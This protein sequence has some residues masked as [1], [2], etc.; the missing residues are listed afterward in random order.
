MTSTA[1]R[2]A[3]TAAVAFGYADDV[4]VRCVREVHDA[5]A[6]RVFGRWWGGHVPKVAHDAVASVAYAGVSGG[7]RGASRGLRRLA[8][9][10][11]GRSVEST[12][13]TRLLRSAVNALV[14]DRLADGKDPY[15]LPMVLR[16]DGADVVPDGAGFAR[17]YPAATGEV[18]VLVHGLGENDDS[19]D[20]RAQRHGRTYD[21]AL[22]EQTAATP[23]R[24]RYNTGRH[25]SDNG[26]ELS[27]LLADLVAAWPVPVTRLHLVGHSMGGLVVRSATAH[28]VAGRAAWTEIVATVVCLGTPHLGAAME[29]AAHAGS[30]VLSAV[31]ESL[32][33]ATV[34]G[35]RSAGIVD[36]RHGYVT[37]DEWHGQDLTARWGDGRLAVAPLPHATYHFVAAA[38]DLIVSGRSAAGAGRDGAVVVAHAS[39]SRVPGGHLGLLN[40]PRI[41]ERLVGWVNGRPPALVTGSDHPHSTPTQEGRP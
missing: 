40:H 25:V 19:W 30:R 23:V 12:P 39:A 20:F 35:A 1:P 11:V 7:L 14:G 6:R 8:D 17:A 22:H 5:V 26:A 4:V 34:L 38:A 15:A 9:R 32:P 36:L 27:D 29:R 28:G 33:F 31:P 41:A 21:D 24:L 37:R 10:G 13:R 2:T 18:V 16:S 3:H